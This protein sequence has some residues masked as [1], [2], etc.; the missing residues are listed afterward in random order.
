[1]ERLENHKDNFSQ[2]K[3]RNRK[4]VTTLIE[5]IKI[6]QDDIQTAL[7]L[8]NNFVIVNK[9][10]KEHNLNYINGNIILIL[11]SNNEIYYYNLDNLELILP[12]MKL[13]PIC[14]K[15]IQNYFLLNKFHISN[16]IISSASLI[17]TAFP[18]YSQRLATIYTPV[19]II[20]TNFFST[21]DFKTRNH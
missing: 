3:S 6:I 13:N 10:Y 12:D 8:T 18:L 19:N 17:D 2:V 4:I 5:N 20:Q 15:G 21:F 16:K 1:M 14:W 11:D 7:T 9:N